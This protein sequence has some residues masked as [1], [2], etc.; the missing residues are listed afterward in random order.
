MIKRGEI[1]TANNDERI[2]QQTTEGWY[3]A[4]ARE[5]KGSLILTNKRL[6]IG[7][8]TNS[9]FLKDIIQ[10]CFLPINRIQIKLRDETIQI[11]FAKRSISHGINQIA[12]VIFDTPFEAGSW[13]E[14]VASYTAYWAS[15]LTTALLLYGELIEYKEI[16]YEDKKAWCIHCEEYVTIPY[17]DTPV[18]KNECPRCGHR[19]MTSLSQE[20]RK[21]EAKTV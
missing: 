3:A 4:L 14:E 6:M 10:I 7:D 21:K 11:R 8:S 17:S 2:I 13:Q 18:W 19:G 16:V 5:V 12:S 20:D 15:V 1:T 9:Y